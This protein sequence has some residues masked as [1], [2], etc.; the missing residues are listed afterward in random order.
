MNGTWRSL[1]DDFEPPKAPAIFGSEQRTR[2]LLLIAVLGETYPAELAKYSGTSIP[3]V[4]LTLDI[5]ER[6]GLI[7]ARN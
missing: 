4:Q 2:L 5:L 3:S 7:S 6:E 1:P